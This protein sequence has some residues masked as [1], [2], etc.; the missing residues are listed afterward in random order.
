MQYDIPHVDKQTELHATEPRL[1]K[2]LS[3]ISSTMLP[4]YLHDMCVYK[5]TAL[6]NRR[7]FCKFFSLTQPTDNV[8]HLMCQIAIS[9]CY[10]TNTGNISL[11]LASVAHLQSICSSVFATSLVTRTDFQACYNLIML[12][13]GCT[14]RSLTSWFQIAA[15]K[16]PVCDFPK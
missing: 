13:C 7:L 16:Y 8:N 3:Y 2:D 10:N 1:I 14:A 11:Q 12:K 6:Y 9:H 15:K 5:L 4:T